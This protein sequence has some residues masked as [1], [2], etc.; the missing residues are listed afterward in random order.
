MIETDLDDAYWLALNERHGMVHAK[1]VARAQK[2]LG[3]LSAILNASSSSLRSIGFQDNAIS[4]LLKLKSNVKL[5]ELSSKLLTIKQMGVR[6]IKFTD[7][8]YPGLLR[9]LPADRNGAPL[10]L[11]H[12]GALIDFDRCVAIAGTRVLSYNG[13]V[14]AR[15]IARAVASAGYTV[16][17]GLARGTDTEAHLGALDVKGGRT[18]AVLAWLDQIYPPENWE[19]AKTIERRGAILSERY[20]RPSAFAPAAFVERNRI[21]SGMSRCVIAVESDEE[22]GTVHQVRLAL[23]QGKTVFTVKPKS[24]DERAKRGFQLFVKMGATP[25]NSPRSV[26]EYLQA[27]EKDEMLEAYLN[28][29][30]KLRT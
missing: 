6:I 17:S 5:E 10:I 22:G 26:L 16:V 1:E 11:F 4:N 28:P 25:I 9:L 23:S 3:S 14:I 13:H 30:T 2:E 12:R 15:Q 7:P 8:T 24:S 18:V 20:D 21:T 27:G 29:Q 19:L